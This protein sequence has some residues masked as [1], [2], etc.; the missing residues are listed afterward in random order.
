MDK[1]CMQ[2]SPP[3]LKRLV[4]NKGSTLATC[5]IRYMQL[6]G[7]FIRTGTSATQGVL[8]NPP[9]RRDCPDHSS[10]RQDY[11]CRILWD[12]SPTPR[13]GSSDHRNQQA[14]DALRLQYHNGTTDANIVL[15]V[16]FWTR[17][18]LYPLA[19][20]VQPLQFPRNS[21]M[22]ENAMGKSIK[23][24]HQDSDDGR[25]PEISKRRQSIYYAS[26]CTEGIQF[27]RASLAQHGTDLPW[28]LVH[29]RH[30][31]SLRQHNKYWDSVAPSPNGIKFGHEIA[32]RT[33]N[34]L[35]HA[36]VEE[37]YS[38]YLSKQMYNPQRGQIHQQ[39]P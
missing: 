38:F 35:R 11:R 19:G 21:L 16:L 34:Q 10:W 22:D 17:S 4:L 28:A 6:D 8:S 14:F 32:T 36:A 37:C 5:W 3:P 13:S 20:V 18:L 23:V 27:G 25:I 15:D 31:N 39:H 29:V 33:T 9:N 30:L 1:W 2:W 26:P 12:R 7:N 24:W